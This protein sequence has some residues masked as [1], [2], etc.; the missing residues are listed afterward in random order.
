MVSF[1]TGIFWTSLSSVFG[2]LFISTL[3]GRIWTAGLPYKMRATSLFYLSPIL[4]LGTLTIIATLLGKR[5]PLANNL[6]ALSLVLALVFGTILREKQKT[7]AIYH[8]SLIGIFGTICGLSILVPLFFYG[9][10]NSHNDSFL[11]LTHSNW[12]QSH[13]FNDRIPLAE[14]TPLKTAVAIFQEQ[15]L[16]MGGSFLLALF[17]GLFRMSWSYELYPSILIAAISACCLAIGFPLASRLRP[18]SRLIRFV[19][20]ACPALT[21]G[22]LVWGA[23]NGFFS[24]TVG[25]S[26]G[27]SLL[28]F[29]GPLFSWI[30]V[31]KPANWAILKATLPGI[32]LLVSV[33]FAYPELDPFIILGLC[34]SAF[35]LAFSFNCW[36]KMV[37]CVA[38]L[39]CF[40][41]LILN[42]ELMRVYSALRI[43]SGAIVG[44]AVEWSLLE[45]I[46]HIFGLY[47]GNGL[48]NTKIFILFILMAILVV[49]R[50]SLWRLIIN[51]KLMP[52][53][54]VLTI[55][56]LSLL[57]YRYFV[58]SP[59]EKGVGQSWSQFKLSDWANPCLMVLVL[60]SIAG[61]QRKFG[62][63]IP[64]LLIPSLFIYCVINTFNFNLK[65]SHYLMNANYAGVSNLNQFYLD[66]RKEVT[67]RCPKDSSVFLA[68]QGQQHK[69]RQMM[70]YYF[71]DRKVKSDW[72]DDTYIFPVLEPQNR[73]QKPQYGDCVIEPKNGNLVGKGFN[74]GSYRIG[75]YE[76]S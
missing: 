3:I 46:A 60:G 2:I 41:I 57:F 48:S 30:V 55:F 4:G 7:L 52:T 31:N 44:A 66:I 15:G 6:I 38:F 67:T 74:I 36:Q 72:T 14:M 8:A 33:T 53:A 75:V 76:T 58:P 34:S 45:Y 73:T 26:F 22:G 49:E 56:F 47:A 68:L 21:F 18:F 24:Q 43:E 69:F 1:G 54:L 35:L 61:L 23:S 29:I 11:Y 51:G 10:F 27:A 42:W 16:R 64:T 19:M 12:L 63:I 62:K 40:S 65:S 71:F 50:R 59:F 37:L 25:L 32:V 17:Q 39:F 20:L 70:V 28:F 13:A 5:F 9:A